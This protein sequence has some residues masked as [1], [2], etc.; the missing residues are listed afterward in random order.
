MREIAMSADS[1]ILIPTDVREVDFYGD[2]ISG[3]LVRSGEEM[4]IYVPMR[5]ICDYL[6]LDW[7]AQ[8]QRMQR[9]E[10][11]REG[12]VII[13]IPSE[14]GPQKMACLPL[15][16]LPGFLF[17]ISATRVKPELKEKILRYQ[18]ECYRVLW[19]AFQTQII[20]S[21]PSATD[22][23][24]QAIM[25][26]EQIIEQSK[27]MQRMAE[28]QITLIRRMDAAAR[29]VK[30][31]QTDLTAT[32][33]DVVEV[34]ADVANVQIRLG[35]LEERLH[36]SAYITDAQAAEVQ[37]AVAAVAMAL[38]EHDPSKNHFQSL[39]AELHRRFKVKSYSLIRVEQYA[40]VLSF[41][42][43]WER[44][45]HASGTGN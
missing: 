5:P 7:S 39:H 12:M 32:Q 11:L 6:G 34:K 33:A 28:E 24:G 4:T 40:A 25:Q 36:P 20:S 30:A 16:F 3:A 15:E 41:L 26:L 31:L 18:R 2:T 23:S 21:E 44:R 43:E 1:T 17:G 29:V 35:E 27:A 22:E 37:S 10:V 38:T 9:E 19:R 14:G 42:E 13:T 8:R 45:I